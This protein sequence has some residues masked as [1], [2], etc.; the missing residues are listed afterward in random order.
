MVMPEF[1]TPCIHGVSNC[2]SMQSVPHKK[3]APNPSGPKLNLVKQVL[4]EQH[5]LCLDYQK[6]IGLSLAIKFQVWK[7]CNPHCKP[8]NMPFLIHF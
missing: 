6:S 3:L 2:D 8:C 1:C 4:E 7:P 5:K